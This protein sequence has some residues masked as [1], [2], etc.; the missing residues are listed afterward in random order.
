VFVRAVHGFGCFGSADA[1]TK[2][3]RRSTI[4]Q[5]FGRYYLRSSS[6]LT[7]LPRP[8]LW[9]ERIKRRVG[10][11]GPADAVTGRVSIFHAGE[12]SPSQTNAS[13]AVTLSPAP[14]T[15]RAGQANRQLLSAPS[16]ERRSGRRRANVGRLHGIPA[17]PPGLAARAAPRVDRRGVRA[18]AAESN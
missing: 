15:Y 10:R 18:G 12:M 2:D 4:P 8:A 5:P 14:A 13:V 11:M 7:C 1:A 6:A 17:P 3:T 16:T 9:L